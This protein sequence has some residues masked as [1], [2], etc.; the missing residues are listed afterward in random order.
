MLFAWIPRSGL[1]LDRA[2]SVEQAESWSA[3]SISQTTAGNTGL[4]EHLVQCGFLNGCRRD[5]LLI[6]QKLQLPVRRREHTEETL[7]VCSIYV[8]VL[9]YLIR[10]S[11][12]LTLVGL[13][14]FQ[15]GGFSGLIYSYFF[16]FF[17]KPH[18]RRRCAICISR[19]VCL[20]VS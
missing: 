3:V 17:M 16:I 4:L 12:S 20:T 14:D 5:T 7:C 8:K 9:N 10:L 19:C 15:I 6:C 18:L 13:L 2:A 1:L 11:H